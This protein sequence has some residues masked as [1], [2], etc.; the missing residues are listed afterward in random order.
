MKYRIYL[1]NYYLTHKRKVLNM[2]K[3]SKFFNGLMAVTILAVSVAAQTP[4]TSWYDSTATSFTVSSADDLAGLAQ[5]VNGTWGGKPTR[6][7]FSGKTVTLITNVDLV[8]YRNWIPIGS[9]NNRFSGTFNGGGHTI[10][11]LTINAGRSSFLGLF[12]RINS[13][14]IENVGLDNINILALNVSTNIGGV[15]GCMD[16]SIVTNCYT[17]GSINDIEYPYGLQTVGGIVGSMD[18]ESDRVSN[19]YSACVIN[20]DLNVGGIVGNVQNGGSV[21]NCY[22]MGTIGGGS[23]MTS[24]RYLGGVVGYLWRGN[25]TN[26]FSTGV[27]NVIVHS[28]GSDCT[29]GGIAGI[30][31]ANTNSSVINCAALNPEIN[32]AYRIGRVGSIGTGYFDPIVTLDEFPNGILSGNVA[33]KEMVNG[34]TGEPTW[35]YKGAGKIDGADIALNA[36]MLDGTIG[37]RFTNGNIWTTRAGMLPGLFGVPVPMPAHLVVNSTAVASDNRTIPPTNTSDD[38]AIVTTINIVTCEFSAGPNPSNKNNGIV[39]IFR[40]GTSIT[41]GTLT[42]YDA[43]GNIVNKISISDNT[44]GALRATPMQSRRIVGSWDLKDAKGR[45]VSDGTYL[46]RGSIKTSDGKTENVSLILGVR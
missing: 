17:T 37:G 33:Y 9:E 43:A 31:Y 27:I 23:R 44:V 45:I 5:I 30:I 20:G 13:A 12:G 11:N 14:R 25:I 16:G 34:N 41:S 24:A 36:I 46:L 3:I 39:K 2:S 8:S 40:R 32:Y 6:D 42:I 7:S 38:A 21:T 1:L 10:S 19:C 15:V 35:N 4:N 29:V 28:A 18:G 22:S 26:C